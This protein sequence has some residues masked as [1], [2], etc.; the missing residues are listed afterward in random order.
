M[1]KQEQID[2]INIVNWFNYTYPDLEE[3]LHHFAN[4]R[5]CTV[6][7]GRLLKRMGVKKG[8]ADFFLA[9]PMNGRS[10]LWIELKVGSNKPSPEQMK[11]LARKILRGFDAAC[12]IGAQAAKELISTYLKDFKPISA[13]ILPK[14]CS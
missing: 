7:E 5:R 13:F 9:I 1:L 2:H 6:Q 3:D 10:G 12:V 4:E 8:V 11:F 14:N